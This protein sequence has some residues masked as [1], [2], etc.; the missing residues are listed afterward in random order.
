[1]VRALTRRY[2]THNSGSFRI[3]RMIESPGRQQQNPIPGGND[4]VDDVDHNQ[5]EK[6]TDHQHIG[7]CCPG[8]SPE[9]PPSDM[10]MMKEKFAKLLLG[11]DM[12]GGGKGV[13][14]ALAL[15]N[16]VTNL[17]AS[18]FGEQVKL[19]PMAP[20]KESKVAKRN[21]L[22]SIG[23][24]SHRRIR[25]FTAENEQRNK[26]G[27]YGHQTKERS[28]HQ[29]T[30]PTQTRHHAYRYFGRE[31]EFWYVSKN[32]DQDNE[33]GHRDD[34]WWHPTV[35]GLRNPVRMEIPES[36]IDSLPR[37]GR[38]SLGDSIY[39]C[40]TVD[41]CDPL[42]FL[43]TMDLSTEHKVSDLKNRIEASIIIWKRKLHHKDG[44][45]SWAS[46]VSLEKRELFEV[47]VEN[48]LILL[49]QRF[50]GLPQSSLDISKIQYNRDVGHAIQESYSRILESLAFNVMSRI[51]DVLHA[52]FFTQISSPVRSEASS[53][54]SG[55]DSVV[56]SSTD[57]PTLSDFMG[58]GDSTDLEIYFKGDHES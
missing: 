49:K 26:H 50:R 39:K 55:E 2:S 47:R 28:S 25:S 42:Q 35:K 56:T 36:Y 31:Q 9:R 22:A 10:D 23:H 43:A 21:G 17:A 40:I 12:S 32:D 58:W 44:R 34:K 16:A 27:G 52:D 3:K 57:T 46:S 8:T 48:I 11:E 30:R 13:S 5:R 38:S 54:S 37:N 41:Q 20:V 19:G 18:V 6:S 45:S 4:H 14:S 24:R 7:D 29:H 53:S 33:N 15:S 51:Q 1:M